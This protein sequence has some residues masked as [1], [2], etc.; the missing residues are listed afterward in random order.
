MRERRRLQFFIFHFSFFILL[1]LAVPAF[2]QTQSTDESAA[3]ELPP[4]TVSAQRL[5]ESTDDPPA[6]VEVLNVMLLRWQPQFPRPAGA[7]EPAK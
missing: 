7:G 1:L 2:A 4:V 6:F 5:N 3:P